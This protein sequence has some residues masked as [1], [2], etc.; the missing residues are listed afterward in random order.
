MTN[1]IVDY[2]FLCS[3]Y[4]GSHWNKGY[5][6]QR[7]QILLFISWAK[8]LWMVVEKHM[9][10]GL[11]GYTNKGRSWLVVPRILRGIRRTHSSVKGWVAEPKN[12]LVERD[13]L[14]QVVQALTQRRRTPVFVRLLRLP[15]FHR[16]QQ[17]RFWHLFGQYAIVFGCPH[18]D[19][20]FLIFNR[21]LF[22]DTSPNVV[23]VVLHMYPI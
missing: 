21:N 4:T 10:A 13:S 15:P 8:C 5:I 7:E 18:D 12:H 17:L 9:Y 14:Y 11:P 20:Y 6:S 22:Y 23:W 19:F 3:H 16:F 2:C 1:L